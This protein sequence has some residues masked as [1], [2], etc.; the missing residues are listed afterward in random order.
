MIWVESLTNPM[1]RHTD[2]EAVVKIARKKK[3]GSSQLSALIKLDTH[4]F[5]SWNCKY[6]PGD[7]APGHS[8]LQ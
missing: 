1:L 7:E 5:R 3:V 6:S 8:L 4:F 2:L